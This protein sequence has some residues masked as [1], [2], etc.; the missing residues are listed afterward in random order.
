MVMES[1]P[2]TCPRSTDRALTI[3]DRAAVPDKSMET[4]TEGGGGGGSN[5]NNILYSSQWEIKAVVRS[6]N[7]EHIS[8]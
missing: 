6:H 2:S 8:Q 4:L 5:N 1:R 3:D 7:E